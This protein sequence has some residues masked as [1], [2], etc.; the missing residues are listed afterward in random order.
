MH[1]KSGSVLL[2]KLQIV[3]VQIIKLQ[4]ALAPQQSQ[5]GKGEGAVQFVSVGSINKNVKKIFFPIMI[6]LFLTIF[7]VY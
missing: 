2:V 5:N 7:F 4:H 6:L 3:V 1:L